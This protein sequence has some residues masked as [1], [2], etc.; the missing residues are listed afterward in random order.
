[1]VKS[2]I[3][4]FIKNREIHK[5]YRPSHS[6]Q[7]SYRSRK[8]N[9]SSQS[10]LRSILKDTSCPTPSMSEFDHLPISAPRAFQN[11]DKKKS[12]SQKLPTSSDSTKKCPKRFS[13]SFSQLPN[14]RC[15]K[16]G[17]SW[18]NPV[19]QA[20]LITCNRDSCSVCIKDEQV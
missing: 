8:S 7:S 1:M 3:V 12:V 5:V 6:S 2:R 11:M 17:L 10:S 20:P 18:F 9:Q 13:R 4:H 15:S 14:S 16:D 19:D